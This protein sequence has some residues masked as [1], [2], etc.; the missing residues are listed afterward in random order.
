MSQSVAEST[1]AVGTFKL[2]RRHT[3][4][5]PIPKR[6]HSCLQ[7]RYRECPHFARHRAEQYR[8]H[9]DTQRA[10]KVVSAEM[11]RHLPPKATE[12]SGRR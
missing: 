10:Q 2:L 7:S 12:S 1:A 11:A 3:M 9:I 4:N 8:E 5:V 6:G